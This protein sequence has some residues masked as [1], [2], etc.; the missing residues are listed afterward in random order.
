MNSTLKAKER[1]ASLQIWVLPSLTP[2]RVLGHYLQHRS[3]IGISG[4]E[5]VHERS[6]P[7]QTHKQDT[8]PIKVHRRYFIGIWEERPDKCPERVD[9]GNNVDGQTSSAETPTTLGQREVVKTTVSDA[10]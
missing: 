6:E 10:A 3:L 4:V 9:E 1:P 2:I 7:H 8:S 5:D